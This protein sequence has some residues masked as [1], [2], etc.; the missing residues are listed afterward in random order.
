VDNALPHVTLPA[1][2]ADQLPHRLSLYLP[3]R[4]ALVLTPT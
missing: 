1:E 3:N 4:T 2:N